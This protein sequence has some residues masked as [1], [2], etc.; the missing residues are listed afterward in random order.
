MIIYNIT[1]KVATGIHPQWMH[2]MR[3]VQIP[4]MM[5][6]GLFHD[7]RM[8]RLLEQ[9]DSEGPTYAIQYFTDSMENYNTFMAE[10]SGTMRQRGYE[11]FGDQFIAFGTV[12]QAI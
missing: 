11:M 2:W 7:Y 4:A 8:C 1:I 12:M 3:E 5:E 9:D 6:T 10:H